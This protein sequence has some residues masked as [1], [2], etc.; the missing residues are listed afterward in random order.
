MVIGLF[1]LT[2]SCSCKRKQPLKPRIFPDFSW[3]STRKNVADSLKY[4]IPILDT[5]FYTD[6]KFREIGKPR[7]FEEN[8]DSVKMYDLK[9]IKVVSEIIHKHGWLGIK[10]I[11]YA[12]YVG[13]TMTIQHSPL[14]SQI[15]FLPIVKEAFYKNKVAPS[16]FAL[17]TDRVA[18]LQKNKQTYGTQ[19]VY[20]K[21]LKAKVIFPT[22]DPDSIIAKRTAINVKQPLDDCLRM[23]GIKWDLEQ[24]K[25]DL[26]ILI[27]EFEVKE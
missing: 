23:L 14:D 5:V 11:G 13:I 12:G 16:T 4:L 10:D 3:D 2:I 9:N 6:Q 22:K 25:K 20:S 17:L 18:M 26:P 24:Y 21:K 1:I 7:L 8:R 27:E 15:K 19:L